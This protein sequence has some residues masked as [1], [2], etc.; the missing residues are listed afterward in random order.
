MNMLK[1]YENLSEEDRLSIQTEAG[2]PKWGELYRISGIAAI[3]MLILIPVQIAVYTIWPMPGSVAEWFKLFQNSP[4]LGLLHLDVLYILNNTIVAIMYLAFY[5]SLRRKN[6]AL[7]L[8]A[9]LTGLLATAA[10]YSSNP[11][12]EMLSLSREFAAGSA[13]KTALLAAGQV[14]IA[15]WKGTA[16]DIYYILSAVCLIIMAGAMFKSAIYGKTMAAI[17][18]S[19]G[20]LMLIPSTAGTLGVFFSLASLVPWFV[21]SVLA[22]IKHLKLS[23][24]SAKV[25]LRDAN[26]TVPVSE[27]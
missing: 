22:A 14:M 9:L 4:L 7:L 27:A 24:I 23:D 5:M 18:L 17:G 20:I 21:F 19:S 25:F 12:F 2:L 1:N 16:F 3:V 26:L 13:D 10:Y 15:Q 6:E 11:A 8:L